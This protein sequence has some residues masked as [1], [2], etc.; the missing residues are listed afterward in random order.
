MSK[1]VC[2][3][4]ASYTWDHMIGFSLSIVFEVVYSHTGSGIGTSFWK[5]PEGKY[6]RLCGPNS[7]NS[8]VFHSPVDGHLGL[9]PL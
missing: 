9:R 2:V 6:F 1:A 7:P 8:T 3:P 4:D 5:G